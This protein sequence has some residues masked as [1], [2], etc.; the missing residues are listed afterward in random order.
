M[1][2]ALFT[3]AATCGIIGGGV[4]LYQNRN[5]LFRPNFAKV[6]GTRLVV[7]VEGDLPGG[8]VV[9]VAEVL[10][11]RFDRH[12]SA[13]IEVREIGDREIE[14][15]V[16]RGTK[17][18]DRVEQVKRLLD[19]TGRLEF[20]LLARA[21]EDGKAFRAADERLR[22]P[23]AKAANPPPPPRAR[24]GSARFASQ[25][26]GEP[27]FTY[28]WAR[29]SP[30]EVKMLR[31]DEPTMRREHTTDLATVASALKHGQPFYPSS[32]PELL[33]AVRKPN[34]KADPVFYALTRQEPESDAITGELIDRVTV[35]R[36]Y[37]TRYLMT[38]QLNREGGQKL[39]SLTTR[40][41][42]AGHNPEGWRKLA[43]ILDGEVLAVQPLT[44]PLV[45]QITLSG[46]ALVGEA[47]D[48]AMLVRGGTLP[49]KLKLTRE[50]EVEPR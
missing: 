36:E 15:A 4:L 3:L 14:I 26:P 7:E 23:D 9:E 20:R 48:T 50:E 38:V 30:N 2:K 40:N 49:A 43:V 1:W 39:L 18:G 5:R 16:P 27:E 29:L 42:L 32:S 21:S 13:G 25:M 47:D 35:S 46:D 24:D 10:R 6:G 8:G 34:E 12:G 22:K 45:G 33:V 11:R 31:L 37:G 44:T 17:H 19:R 28:G 41:V